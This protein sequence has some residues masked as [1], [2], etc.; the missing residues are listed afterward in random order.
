MNQNKLSACTTDADG[1]CL[2][3]RC[4][5]PSWILS[6]RQTLD[7]ATS[8]S[9][10][11]LPASRGRPSK[12][13]DS[14]KMGMLSLGTNQWG[15]GNADD[16]CTSSGPATSRNLH[17]AVACVTEDR[18]CREW[19]AQPSRWVPSVVPPRPTLPLQLANARKLNCTQLSRSP[20]RVPPVFLA[21]L[22]SNQHDPAVSRMCCPYTSPYGQLLFELTRCLMRV[23]VSS[24]SNHVKKCKV[25][26]QIPPH[27]ANVGAE[28][29]SDQSRCMFVCSPAHWRYQWP[30]P[31]KV[32]KPCQNRATREL[33]TARD[34]LK[35]RADIA[36]LV[37][38]SQAARLCGALSPHPLLFIVSGYRCT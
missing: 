34:S 2:P 28:A 11:V 23:S 36:V 9:E 10:P 25:S 8:D 20:S 33:L 14:D 15:I 4:G 13:A 6:A 38:C 5:R 22:G 31:C 26:T 3:A 17:M 21:R 30:R 19:T 16:P 35:L 24:T 12:R 32:H 37:H 7:E 18:R 1:L 27:D 29:P